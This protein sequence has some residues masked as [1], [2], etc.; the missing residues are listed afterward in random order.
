MRSFPGY[1]SNNGC[2]TWFDRVAIWFIRIHVLRRIFI[3]ITSE[4]GL[5]NG[6]RRYGL[7]E[8]AEE[9]VVGVRSQN[10]G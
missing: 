1:L 6:S 4:D 10:S 2:S 5:Y 7:L 8:N 9:F 3:V